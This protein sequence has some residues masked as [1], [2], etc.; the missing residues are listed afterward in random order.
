[1]ATWI[2]LRHG[3]SVANAARRLAGWDDVGL[4]DFGRHQA[5][6]AGRALRAHPLDLVLSSDLQRAS[7]TARLAV[8]AWAGGTRAVPEIV[9]HPELR[10]RRL[11]VLQGVPLAKAR[12]TG[13][14][15]PL[16]TWTGVVEGGES[17]ADLCRRVLGRLADYD[18][19]EGTA[20]LVAHG[21]VIRGLRGLLDGLDHSQIGNTKVANATPLLRVL[22]PGTWGR[23]DRELQA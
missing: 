10:E 1:M 8:E 14:L 6:G 16:R 19:V 7:H 18:E 23:L 3:Q 12:R 21:G 20:L 17:Q 15:D 2:L 13:A 11:G 9:C 5:R 4:T 22:R